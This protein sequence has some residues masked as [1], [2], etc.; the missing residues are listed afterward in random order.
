MRRTNTRDRVVNIRNHVENY[1]DPYLV[2]MKPGRRSSV[3]NASLCSQGAGGSY[4]I[5]P[6]RKSE[7]STNQERSVPPAGRSISAILV[8]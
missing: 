2:Q 8:A 3:E 1:G 7:K 5:R 4:R 6:A